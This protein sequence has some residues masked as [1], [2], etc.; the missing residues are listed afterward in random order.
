MASRR[1]FVD[2]FRFVF[3]AARAQDTEGTWAVNIML[4]QVP[5]VAIVRGPP[6]LAH[7]LTNRSGLCV[8]KQE[9]GCD[10]QQKLIQ[11]SSGR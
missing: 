11:P 5:P 4:A 3:S 2:V 1:G 9:R 6:W 8:R 7:R 10:A